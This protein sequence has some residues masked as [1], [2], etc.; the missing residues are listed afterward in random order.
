MMAPMIQ[1]FEPPEQKPR[2]QVSGTVIWKAVAGF[3]SGYLAFLVVVVSIVAVTEEAV[4]R[5][6]IPRGPW[7]LLPPILLGI[8]TARIFMR[9]EMDGGFSSNLSLFGAKFLKS[10]LILGGAFFGLLLLLLGPFSDS[11]FG[12]TRW[13]RFPLFF[14][15]IIALAAYLYRKDIKQE[16]G[17]VSKE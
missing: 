12:T 9:M 3:C 14:I 2:P 13:W 5:Q 16:T 11:L 8:P 7:W 17:D 10:T 15:A 4:G 1:R 6:I